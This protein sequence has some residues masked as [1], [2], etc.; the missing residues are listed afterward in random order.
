MCKC[1][2]LLTGFTYLYDLIHLL[3]H[4]QQ[5]AGVRVHSPEMSGHTKH[6]TKSPTLLSGLVLFSFKAP[7][8][9]V[10]EGLFPLNWE[11]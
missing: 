5:L 8:L 11:K 2:T 10:S 1:K 9:Y 6:F 7:E 4:S 3:W